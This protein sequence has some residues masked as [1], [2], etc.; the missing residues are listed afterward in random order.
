MAMKKSKSKKAAPRKSIKPIGRSP[1]IAVR[2]PARL[3]ERITKSAKDNGRSMSEEMAW[4]IQ[5]GLDWNLALDA[6][7]LD[8]GFQRIEGTPHWFK[9]TAPA[10]IGTPSL[11]Q[12]ETPSAEEQTAEATEVQKQK[13]TT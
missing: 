9:R 6:G 8:K 3:H 4:L 5:A 10:S 2:V 12:I 7:L 11:T 1:V 13:G